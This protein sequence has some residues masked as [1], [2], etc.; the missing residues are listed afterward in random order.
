MLSCPVCGDLFGSPG[1]PPSLPALWGTWAGAGP[2]PGR[3]PVPQYLLLTSLPT[4]RPGAWEP[5]GEGHGR[6]FQKEPQA[7]GRETVQGISKGQ[8]GMGGTKEK[9]S[10]DPLPGF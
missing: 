10:E 6:Q 9:S 7:P 8:A 2:D 5:R 3:F 1:K 4:G